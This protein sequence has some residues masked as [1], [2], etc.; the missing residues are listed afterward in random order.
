MLGPVED[1]TEFD[2]V[3]AVD[4]LSSTYEKQPD[5]TYSPLNN[6]QKISWERVGMGGPPFT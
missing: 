2:E 3:L 1:E 5:C 6:T 4:D